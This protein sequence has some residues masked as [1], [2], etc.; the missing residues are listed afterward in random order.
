[1]IFY[2]YIP[3][4]FFYQINRLIK[5][6]IIEIVLIKTNSSITTDQQIPNHENTNKYLLLVFKYSIYAN[7][8]KTN[9]KIK[10]KINRIGKE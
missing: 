3:H 4:F 7:D 10:L 6:T 2:F 1:M 9:K 8:T 5:K